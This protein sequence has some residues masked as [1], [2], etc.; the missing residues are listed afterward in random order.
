MSLDNLTP[1]DVY[2]GR[3][4]ECLTV[5]EMNKRETMKLR[6]TYNMAKGGLKKQ[7]RLSKIK[8]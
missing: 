2:F 1:A 3:K 5:R 6:C 4:R 8:P 7:L